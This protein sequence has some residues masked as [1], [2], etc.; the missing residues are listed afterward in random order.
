MS[1]IVTGADRD[2]NLAHRL[3]IHQVAA[4]GRETALE[5]GVVKVMWLCD[6]TRFKFLDPNH[7]S[8]MT[9]AIEL[10]NFVHR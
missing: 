7:V 2:L 5:R 1:I 6:A 3:N 9:K 8:G 4:Y 10:S